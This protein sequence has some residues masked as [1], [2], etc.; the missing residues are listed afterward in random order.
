[1]P[2]I[3]SKKCIVRNCNNRTGEGSFKG[4]L[5]TPCH[6]FIT[7]GQGRYSQMYRNSVGMVLQKVGES[8]LGDLVSRLD[9]TATVQITVK[10]IL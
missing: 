9:P 7:T 10:E 4:N 8:F 1:M 5:C 2:K 6:T 3:R